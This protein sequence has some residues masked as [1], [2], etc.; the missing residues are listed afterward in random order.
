MVRLVG[1]MTRLG[2]MVGSVAEMVALVGELV[3]MVDE[4][5]L[6]RRLGDD[7]ERRWL[8]PRALGESDPE[9]LRRVSGETDA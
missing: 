1:E 4:M 9:D 8:L 5:T 2:E 3:V 6:R 7:S